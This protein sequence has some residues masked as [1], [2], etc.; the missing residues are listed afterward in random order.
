LSIDSGSVRAR[1]APSASGNIVQ[2]EF[3]VSSASP[4]RF[5]SDGLPEIAFLGR[6]N[7]G[8]SSIINQLVG[9][10]RLAHTSNRP[11]RTRT[12]NFYRVNRAF[13]FVDLPGYGY[14]EVSR[15]ETSQWKKLIE[16]YLRQRQTLVLSVVVLDIRRGWMDSDLALRGWL[17]F[18]RR[19][20]LVIATKTDKLNQAQEKRGLEAIAQQ[21]GAPLP[22]SAL[23]GRGVREIW[24]AISKTLNQ[25]LA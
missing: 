11:G 15:K 22:F 16:D 3:V 12:V 1:S 25:S 24:Q 8:K 7:T 5:P 4:D 23:T 10:R 14:A 19:R 20:H 2:A 17:E 18:Y 9:Q 13:Y 21:G 6:S